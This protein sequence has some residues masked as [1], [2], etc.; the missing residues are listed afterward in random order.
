MDDDG[1][2]TC[3]TSL[4]RDGSGDFD[5][6][7]HTDLAEFRAGTNP[8]ND[9]SILRV[10]SLT[11]ITGSGTTLFWCAAPG[12]TYLVQYRNEVNDTSWNNL[13]GTVTATG[14]T[15]SRLDD[16]IGATTNRSYRVVLVAQ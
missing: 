11:S 7:G 9:E 10:I 2:M 15:A 4:S 3:L 16:T 12:R 14:T 8:I 5:Q 13:P 6:D 1:E